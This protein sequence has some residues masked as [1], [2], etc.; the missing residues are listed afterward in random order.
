MTVNIPSSF[1]CRISAG[2]VDMIPS[3][4]VV[5]WIKLTAISFPESP[6]IKSRWT[7]TV[8]P[9]SFSRPTIPEILQISPYRTNTIRNFGVKAGPQPLFVLYGGDYGTI[10]KLFHQ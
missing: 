6:E 2:F 10:L 5:L 3:A 9:A 7:I 8:L 1:A 4:A